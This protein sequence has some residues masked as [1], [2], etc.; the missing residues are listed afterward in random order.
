VTAFHVT[1]LQILLVLGLSLFF[2]FA[3][4]EIYSTKL[5]D[6]PGGARTFPLLAL[7]GAS[8]YILEPHFGSAFIVGLL[9]LGGWLYAYLYQRLKGE[10]K[11]SEGLLV[12][13]VS[14]VL[15]YL[16]GPIAITQ[17]VWLSVGIAVAAVLLVGSRTRLHEI[18]RSVST[19]EYLIAGQFLILIGIALP[20]SYGEP[21]IPHTGITPF[22]I[23]LAV[24]AV[25]SISYASYLAQRFI[26]GKG[27]IA[28]AILGGL[29]SSTATTVVLARRS[30]TEGV[31]REIE[32]GI[33][34]ATAMMYLRVLVISLIFNLDL[35]RALAPW[36][37]G[38]SGAMLA[39]AWLR[40]KQNP[41]TSQAETKGDE[42]QNP[43]QLG[44]AFVF[45]ILL[46]IISVVA[47]WVQTHLGRQG[48]IG[49]AAIVGFAD[50]DPFVLSL[51]QG[52]VAN[53]GLQTATMAILIATSS[54]NALK[55]VYAAAFARRREI[56][57]AVSA[58]L[59]SA[60][61]GVAIALNFIK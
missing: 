25:S 61:A 1:A 46:V 31:T 37:L 56:I 36:L 39:F 50:I 40:Y 15:A 29:Y 22:K 21:P 48:I 7:A 47:S 26:P 9:A 28:S 14:N 2:G 33:I 55:A 51:A 11:P 17:P 53:V 27:V 44:T 13:P 43:L 45:A 3:F 12:V 5:P 8:L 32:S 19:S 20:L 4:E 58:L 35:A 23:T 42:P 16:L 38:L 34:A 60:I 24:V 41:L 30:R 6:R 18:A 57:I 49:L 54:N 52:G 59:L 10:D